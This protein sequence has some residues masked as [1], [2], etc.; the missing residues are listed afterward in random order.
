MSHRVGC[1]GGVVRVTRGLTK[2]LHHCPRCGA[3]AWVSLP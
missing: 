1:T 3:E 2:S